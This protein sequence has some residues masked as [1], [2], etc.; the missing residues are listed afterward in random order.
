MGMGVAGD[1]TT[2]TVLESIP[3]IIGAA[4]L[5]LSEGNVV[6]PLITQIDFPGPGYIHQ[7][8]FVERILATQADAPTLGVIEMTG[9]D[10]TSASASCTVAVHSVWVQLKDLANLASQEDLAALAGQIIGNAIVTRRDLD[11]VTL[12]ASFTIEQGGKLITQMTPADLYDA[13]G[14]LRTYHAALPY[15]LV[16]NPSQI[17]NNLGIIS[18]FD[19]S[20][21]AMQSAG[22]GTVGED[23]A[24]AGFAGMVM[25]FNLWS[26]TNITFTSTANCIGA[27]FSK[28]ALKQ[29]YKR[30]LLIEVD[31]DLPYLATQIVGSEIRGET[32]LRNKSANQ[33]QFTIGKV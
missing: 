25:G 7:T 15:H 23:F 14:S 21:D 27:A 5:E 24:R 16:L 1:T 30:G 9:S 10:E 12:F 3:T 33:M 20:S 32:V 4:L 31:R 22:L 6:A 11:L 29:V 8:P 18:F 17:W 28:E 2:T 13:Y 26:D 19:N